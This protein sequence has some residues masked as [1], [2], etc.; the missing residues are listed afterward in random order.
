[1][2]VRSLTVGFWV[3]AFVIVVAPSKVIPFVI[4]STEV[5]LAVPAGT[6]TVSPPLAALMAV[7]TS[8]KAGLRAVML[9]AGAGATTKTA[10]KTRPADPANFMDVI[11]AIM[12]TESTQRADVWN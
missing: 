5:Q 1:M 6:T 7:L 8:A 9:A 12:G 10:A 3:P 2:I 4:V 11:M